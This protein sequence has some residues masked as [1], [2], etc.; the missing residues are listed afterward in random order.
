MPQP[1]KKLTI[2]V[3]LPQWLRYCCFYF[4]D[5]IHP[6]AHSITILL[7]MPSCNY[8]VWER[9]PVSWAICFRLR[10]PPAKH[11]TNWRVITH[12]PFSAVGGA[13]GRRW[14]EKRFEPPTVR[15]INL[16]AVSARQST[17]LHRRRHGGDGRAEGGGPRTEH[18]RMCTALWDT[19]DDI[20]HRRGLAERRVEKKKT[21]RKLVLLLKAFPRP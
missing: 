17:H 6:I 12:L 18:G 19:D 9:I 10:P 1:S 8:P 21:N 3:L 4:Q 20:I 15:H 16:C 13:V 5:L 2:V 7:R 14:L 11:I